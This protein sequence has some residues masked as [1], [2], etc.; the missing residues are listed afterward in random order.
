M[1]ITTAIKPASTPKP[2]FQKRRLFNCSI[3]FL[4]LDTGEFAFTA[5]TPLIST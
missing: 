1:P 2:I 5:A 3:L 4:S